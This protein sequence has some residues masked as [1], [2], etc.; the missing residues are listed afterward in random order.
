MKSQIERAREWLASR[1]ETTPAEVADS[2]RLRGENRLTR[3]RELLCFHRWTACPDGTWHPW[4]AK[5][6]WTHSAQD[7]ERLL[8]R[9]R[10]GGV[11]DR[12][13]A[14]EVLN[15]TKTQAMYTL[16]LLVAAGLV[17]RRGAFRNAFYFATGL[18]RD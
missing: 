12:T 4:N 7:C 9:M 14:A 3:A 16:R 6:N 15:C 10:E 11:W 8:H 5:R 17:Q 1:G 18:H 2:L 13:E